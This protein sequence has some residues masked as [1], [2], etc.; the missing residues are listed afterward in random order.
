MKPKTTYSFFPARYARMK[1]YE[2]Y[3]ENTIKTIQ[4]IIDLTGKRVVELGAGTGNITF[5]LV[6]YAQMV[7]AFDIAE[8]MLRIARK[9]Q[10]KNKT[11]NCEFRFGDH[12]KI[13]LPDNSA[14][15]IVIGWALNGFVKLDDDSWKSDL[16]EII[17]ECFR[18]LKDDGALLILET[19]NMAGELPWGEIFHPNRKLLAQYLKEK[20]QFGCTFYSNDWDFKNKRNIKKSR[21][22]LGDYLT[23]MVLKSGSVIM[24]ECVGIWSNGMKT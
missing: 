15:V 7:H 22:F 18:V 13:P 12:R 9:Q 2:D 19:A 24:E 5:Q 8:P 4:S 1:S 21:F 6:K 14:H 17:K 3:Q 20:Y 16:D 11:R 23:D 10:R